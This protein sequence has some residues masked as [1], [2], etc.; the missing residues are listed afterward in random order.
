MKKIFVSSLFLCLSLY[1]YSQEICITHPFIV[2]YN[3]QEKCYERKAKA[4]IKK[5]LT[6]EHIYNTLSVGPL[7]KNIEYLLIPM[8]KMALVDSFDYSNKCDFIN[9]LEFHNKLPFHDVIMFKEGKF[10]GV[11]VC[12]ELGSGGVSLY[13][14]TPISF[15]TLIS[16]VNKLNSIDYDQVFYVHGIL[17]A[18]WI[19]QKEDMLVFSLLDHE[20][21]EPQQFLDKFYT[22]EKI[23]EI[24]DYFQ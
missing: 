13:R 19:V 24:I 7:L 17:H 15:E 1:G 2:E 3:N 8:Y 22:D 9:S 12:D 20:F 5:D 10:F 18:W 11:Y 14:D 4:L 23:R 21:Y 6:K 16:D